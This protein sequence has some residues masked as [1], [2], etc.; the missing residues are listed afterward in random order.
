MLG[1]CTLLV[2]CQHGLQKKLV[3]TADQVLLALEESEAL[4]RQLGDVQKVS[5]PPISV[6]QALVPPIDVTLP[7][8]LAEAQ[9]K[10]F[11][12]AVQDIPAQQFFMGLVAGTPYS[13]VVSPK[14]EG[15]IS[16]NLKQVTIAGALKAVRDGYGFE[17]EKTPYGYRILPAGLHTKVFD[18]HYLNVERRGNTL[19]RITSGQLTETDTSGSGSSGGSTSSSSGGNNNL[20]SASISTKTVTDFW[21]ELR[22]MLETMVGQSGGHS[23]V[24]SPQSGTVVVRAYPDELRTVAEFL[25]HTER[26]LTRQVILEAKI[27]EVRLHDGYQAGIDWAYITNTATSRQGALSPIQPVPGGLGSAPLRNAAHMGSSFG[28][29]TLQDLGDFN[30]IFALGLNIGNFSALLKLLSTQGTVQVLSSP[31]ISTVNNQKAVIKVGNDEFFVTDVSGNSS[32]GAAGAVSQSQNVELTPFFSGISLDVTPHIDRDGSVILHIHPMVSQVL[33]DQKDFQVQGQAT[34]LP[35]A[36]SSIRETDSIVRAMNG[37]VIVIGGLMVNNQ[38]ETLASTPVMGDLPLV[39][40][41]FKRTKQVA[42]KSELVIL[43]RPIV[44]ERDTWNKD[45]KGVKSRLQKAQQGFHFG[46]K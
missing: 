4:N 18:V 3:Q 38:E 31:R 2:A 43:L 36:L 25:A 20:T 5:T 17:Y 7:P 12:I 24:V 22:V 9:H 40:S 23:V 35:L 42:S 6:T 34:S 13:M 19:T 11:D 28:D 30:G 27:L 39:G 16:L 41:L 8:A 14:V 33:N 29:Q 46:S 21:A 26:S 10:R 1:S 37:Q 15:K 45:M 44:V 32:Q